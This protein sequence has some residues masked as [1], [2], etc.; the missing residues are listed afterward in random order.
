MAIPGTGHFLA[1]GLP[2]SCVSALTL[3]LARTATESAVAH[4]ARPH[5]AAVSYP[6]SRS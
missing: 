3:F 6:L 1:E 4:D 2:T 5:A